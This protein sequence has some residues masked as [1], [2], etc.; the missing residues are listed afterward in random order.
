L[1]ELAGHGSQKADVMYID[2]AHAVL[3]RIAS[4]AAKTA[5]QGKRVIVLNCEKIVMTGNR[6]RLLR[7]YISDINTIKGRH[8]GP[9]WPRQ[10]DGIV[11]RSIRGMIPH[12][13]AAGAAAFKRVEVYVGVPKDYSNVK[14][15][16]FDKAKMKEGTARF[17]TVGQLSEKITSKRY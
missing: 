1:A 16:T 10:P 15:H 14:M 6:D 3:G 5:L 7:E 8:K 17:M 4:Y 9:F 2:G 13:K 12:K 11:R